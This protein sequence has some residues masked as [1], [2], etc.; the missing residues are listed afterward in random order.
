MLLNEFVSKSV[1]EIFD[2]KI[3]SDFKEKVRTIPPDNKQ[4]QKVK[5]IIE[6]LWN[7]YQKHTSDNAGEVLD[8]MINMLSKGTEKYDS[9]TPQGKAY[10]TIIDYLEGLKSKYTANGTGYSYWRYGNNGLQ[11]ITKTQDISRKYVDKFVGKVSRG[12]AIPEVDKVF[13]DGT[14][15]IIHPISGEGAAAGGAM[16]YVAVLLTGD[17]KQALK[18]L[19]DDAKFPPEDIYHIKEE[20]KRMFL[21]KI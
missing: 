9:S 7:L 19:I 12:E 15:V 20:F 5:T 2:T 3:I 8:H 10:Q 4:L 18:Q 14:R 6:Q 21:V 1:K 16:P 11:N 13:S 17:H